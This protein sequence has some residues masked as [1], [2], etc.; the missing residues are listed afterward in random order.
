[1]I[2]KVAIDR[3]SLPGVID[4]VLRLAEMD[5]GQ[6]DEMPVLLLAGIRAQVAVDLVRD[7]AL[8]PGRHLRLDPR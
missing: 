8:L 4:A 7:V 1:M 5:V 3:R 6:V 2:A